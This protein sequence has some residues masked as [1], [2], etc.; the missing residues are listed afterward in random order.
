MM[1][2]V[3]KV[4]CY[5]RD[6]NLPSTPFRKGVR[7]RPFILELGVFGTADRTRVRW[8]TINSGELRSS[9]CSLLKRAS[10]TFT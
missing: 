2:T 3:I 4:Y 6:L 5:Q 7:S 1:M 10:E 9:R 8:L